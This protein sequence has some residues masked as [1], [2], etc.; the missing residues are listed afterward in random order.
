MK[1]YDTQKGQCFLGTVRLKATPHAKFSI[2]ILGDQHHCDEAKAED[3]PH[4]D[5]EALKK[6]N[7]NK[8][9]VRKHDA[10]LVSESL[11]K[12]MPRILGP[13]P[14]K[15]DTTSLPS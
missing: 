6:L 1:N 14:N 10:F 9:L 8:K 13:G 15:A 5:I 2:C 4:M 7:K 12:Q 11:I 3:I